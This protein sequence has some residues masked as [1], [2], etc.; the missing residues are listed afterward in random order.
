MS[1]QLLSES[2]VS[3]EILHRK[4]PTLLQ[5]S[6]VRV[7]TEHGYAECFGRP[8]S[9]VGSAWEQRA[10]APV[11]CHVVRTKRLGVRAPI[12]LL[13]L[14][15]GALGKSLRPSLTGRLEQLEEGWQPVVEVHKTI[16]YVSYVVC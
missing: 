7:L 11:T 6:L 13:L 8:D 14:S 5:E 16:S 15:G 12:A 10:R 9:A 3:V 2:V 1:R 4:Y